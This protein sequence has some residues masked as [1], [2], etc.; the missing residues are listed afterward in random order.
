M[1]QPQ[2]IEFT[3]TIALLP[4]LPAGEAWGC[5]VRTAFEQ[6]KS[7]VLAEMTDEPLDLRT[8][9]D[10][11]WAAYGINRVENPGELPLRGRLTAPS[12][13]NSQEM[14]IYLAFA[15]GVYRY[16]NGY[17]RLE[18]VLNQDI[19]LSIAGKQEAT[20]QAPVIILVVADMETLRG[21]DAEKKR[22]IAYIDGGIVSQNISIYC[23]AKGLKTRVR[24]SM[25]SDAVRKALNL[26]ERYELILN[27]PV[28]R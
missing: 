27:H 7:C 9:S 22:L 15:Q 6:R 2:A 1:E 25:D 20:A 21:K 18:R 28:A 26:S 8:L 10:L 14:V 13:M 23:A 17:N 4:P 11:L 12:K 19:R 3:D 16:S 24:S 5:D